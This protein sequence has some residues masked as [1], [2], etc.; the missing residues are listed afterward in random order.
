[1]KTL[2]LVLA[3][4]A[5]T[6]VLCSSPTVIFTA[7]S[8]TVKEQFQPLILSCS[9]KVSGNN[10]IQDANVHLL[11]ILHETK[12]IIARI[13]KD[14]PVG[15][16][17]NP[18]SIQVQGQINENQAMHSYLQVT[19]TNPKFTDSGKYFCLAH[20]RNST[21]Q[22]NVLDADITINVGKLTTDDLTMVVSRLLERVDEG[23]VKQEENRQKILSVE[24]D[25]TDRLVNTTTV[26]SRLLER[27][28]NGEEKQDENSRKLL[29]MEENVYNLIANLSRIQEALNQNIEKATLKMETTTITTS[30]G[31]C[32]RGFDKITYGQLF[33][34]VWVSSA[35]LDFFGARGSCK[36]LGAHLMTLK[37][38]D[39]FNLLATNNVGN[40][41]F[42]IGL[43][44]FVTEGIFRWTDDDSISNL[45]S[46][47]SFFRTG[48]PN[49]H[50]GN[51][52]CVAYYPNEKLL[53]DVNC[54]G[55]S[56]YICE[57]PI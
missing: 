53:N 31:N 13:S 14:Q 22:D 52:D 54:F 36:A 7:N 45:S 18:G 25:L 4:C 46:I 34:C 1:M 12:R 28:N 9:V 39:K 21:S 37:T 41:E 50:A 33:A 29:K 26:V 49:D 15:T 10:P 8:E 48:E 38:R 24:E 56:H 42:Y 2:H 51:E 35:P 16:S 43:T 57:Q 47:Q 40:K 3:L 19:W 44:D 30:R 20:V 11:Y 23:K 27:V 5:F 6:T 55:Q 32:K 17:Q